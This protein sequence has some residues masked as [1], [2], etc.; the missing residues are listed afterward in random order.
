LK[1]K[2]APRVT[3][4]VHRKK[5]NNSK[6]FTYILSA[7]LDKEDGMDVPVVL[8]VRKSKNMEWLAASCTFAKKIFQN[9]TQRNWIMFFF[10]LSL[11]YA[12]FPILQTVTESTEMLA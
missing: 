2:T 10:K 4:D 1:G 5:R 6:H 11:I 3:A 8:V 7:D 12:I 9:T